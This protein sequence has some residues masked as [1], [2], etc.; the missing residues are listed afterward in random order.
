MIQFEKILYS[1]TELADTHLNAFNDVVRSNEGDFFKFSDICS[2][3]YL[4]DNSETF[5][6]VSH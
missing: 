3:F 2:E 5:S 4:V 1:V 6:R